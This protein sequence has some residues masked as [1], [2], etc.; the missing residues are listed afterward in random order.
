MPEQKVA[1]PVDLT[2]IVFGD[3]IYECEHANS[4][5]NYERGVWFSLEWIDKFSMCP[6]F[7][8]FNFLLQNVVILTFI[9]ASILYV[10]IDSGELI[11]II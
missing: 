6:V 3:K 1:I 8:I 7:S 9:R 5:S 2:K 11:I 10:D 4:I